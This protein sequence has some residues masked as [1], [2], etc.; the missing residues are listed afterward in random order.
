MVQIHY[1]PSGKE[2]KD[3]SQVGIWFS[4]KP[5]EKV[6]GSIGL[7]S[8]MLLIPAGRSDYEAI[9][10][11]SHAFAMVYERSLSRLILRG[12]DF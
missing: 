8:K 10:K 11:L 3:E 6:I 12:A 2:E 1:H 9:R 5:V 4:D 7:R